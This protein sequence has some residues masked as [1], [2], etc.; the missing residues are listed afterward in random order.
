M[1]HSVGKFRLSLLWSRVLSS[2]EN[3]SLIV[4]FDLDF[5]ILILTSFDVI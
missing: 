2:S 4:V 1:V 5:E 3:E